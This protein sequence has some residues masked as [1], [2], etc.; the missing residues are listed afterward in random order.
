MY[1]CNGNNINNGYMAMAKAMYVCIYGM[2]V[3]RQ[4]STDKSP[5]IPTAFM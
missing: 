5:I 2:Y 4:G 1:V 3:L